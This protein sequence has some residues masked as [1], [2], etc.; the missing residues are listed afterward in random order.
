[1]EAALSAASLSRCVESCGDTLSFEAGSGRG[2][3]FWRSSQEIAQPLSYRIANP[4]GLHIGC[5]IASIETHSRGLGGFSFSGSGI[6]AMLCPEGAQDFH[7]QLR[8]QSARACGIFLSLAD[9]AGTG[10]A[11]VQEIAFTLELD[12]PLQASSELPR[13]LIARLCAPVEP[14]FQGAARDL[15]FE[16]RALEMTALALS[17]LTRAHAM[18][19]A[20]QIHQRY[21]L[22]ARDVLDHRLADPPTLAELAREVGINPRSLTE[23]FRRCFGT[24][25]AAYVTER[26]L[27][28]ALT[29]LEQGMTPGAAAHQIGF[30]ASHLSNAFHR[31][32]GFRPSDLRRGRKFPPSQG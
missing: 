17:W 7:T 15:A 32:F 27:D 31:R 8:G 21:A 6:T 24:S 20:P 30:T 5:G 2:G 1:M 12:A 26:R 29:L 16:A 11:A 9:M 10:N 25:V 19:P 3:A 13:G 28:L 14:W 18:E 4:A 23:V 22:A